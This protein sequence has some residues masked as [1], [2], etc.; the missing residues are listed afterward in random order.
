MKLLST[1]GK[2]ELRYN[3]PLKDLTSFK[4]GG[5][6]RYLFLPCN[7]DELQMVVRTLSLSKIPYYILG[8]GSNILISDGILKTPIIKLGRGFVFIKRLSSSCLEV[9][10]ATPLSNLLSYC[11]KE[12]L[13]GLEVF[14]GLPATCGGLAVMNTSSFGREFFSLV[15]DV[16]VLDC[17]ANRRRLEKNQIQ[18]GYRYTSLKDF[19]VTSIRL[20]LHKDSNVRDRV[21]TFFR[22]RTKS[23]ELALPSLGCVFKN[24]PQ[25]AAGYLIERCGLKGKNYG[26]AY[27]SC[28]HA[29]FI[30]NKGGAKAWEVAKLITII[31]EAV[32]EKF[33]VILEEEI[34][35]WQV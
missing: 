12:N 15:R 14:A 16:E 20:V 19:I 32:Y 10:A 25:M 1:L 30:V 34:V 8:G 24:P 6:A 33:G 3:W 11:V 35:R 29:N 31:K 13:G 21:Y 27:V 9:G 28:K 4:I 22:E 7:E 5:C 26:Q 23:Q 18:Y 17:Q 2:V